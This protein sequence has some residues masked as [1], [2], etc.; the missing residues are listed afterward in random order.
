[1]SWARQLASV[2]RLDLQ[3]TAWF[4][5]IGTST[6]GRP[7][8]ST[9]LAAALVIVP[10]YNERDNL[11]IVVDG[12]MAHENVRLMIVDDQSPDGTGQLAD[13]LAAQHAG[14]V[15][16]MHRTGPRGL[17]RSYLDGFK[18]ALTQ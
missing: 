2:S 17:G 18:R 13:S 10:T 4:A 8:V 12:L 14:R 6:I 1:M 9:K 15:D 16:V 11:P 3:S 5:S 7:D